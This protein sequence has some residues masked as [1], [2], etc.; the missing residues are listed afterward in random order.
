MRRWRVALAASLLAA[1]LPAIVLAL[2]YTFIVTPL[3]VTVGS[4]T[5]FTFTVRNG[6]T[7][8][9]GCVDVL[10]PSALSI[11]SLG[12]PAPSNGLP[13][14]STRSGQRVLVSSNTTSGRLKTAQWVTFTVTAR[15][16]TAGAYLFDYHVHTR[17]DCTGKSLPGTV[18]VPLTVLPAATP[19]PTASPTVGPTP[20][21]ADTPT[22]SPRRTPGP[23]P[24]ATP[25]APTPTPR[26]SPSAGAS[27]PVPSP[28]PSSEPNVI[29]VA[30][31]GPGGGGGG[32]DG[33]LGVGVD[34]LTLLDSPFEWAVPGAVVG[35]PGLLVVLFVVLQ[36]VGALAW[37]PAVRRMGD[38]DDRR[39]R[40]P[41]SRG[42]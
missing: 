29:Q 42:A 34:M 14:S 15:A 23:G 30:P 19:L 39:R 7:Q 21:P 32:D 13:W 11:S 18:T 20:E 40:R 4:V 26:P 27:A 1:G 5:T 6:D 36:A 33:D 37:I 2:V 25:N 28:S 31:L 3:V 9:I 38:Q 16:T 12:T 35:V 41:V 17:R 10:L 22:P 24:R 8:Q